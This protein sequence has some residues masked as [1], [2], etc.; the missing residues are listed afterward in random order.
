MAPAVSKKAP[1]ARIFLSVPETITA[2]LL[3]DSANFISASQKLGLDT[4]HKSPVQT[5]GK[6]NGLDSPF[7]RVKE[8]RN[9]VSYREKLEQAG[10]LLRL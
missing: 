10:E 8:T 4:K 7:V 1:F 2:K 5:R 3:R 6:S 9:L